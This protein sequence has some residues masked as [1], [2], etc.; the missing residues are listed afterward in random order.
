MVKKDK[1]E[2][3][4]AVKKVVEEVKSED[5]PVEVVVE[6]PDMKDKKIVLHESGLLGYYDDDGHFKSSK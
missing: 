5:I 4:D 6:K 1:K 3:K 2:V